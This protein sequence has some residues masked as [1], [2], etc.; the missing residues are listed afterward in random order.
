MFDS[1]SDKL[2]AALA[3]V[4]GRGTLTEDDV[5]AAMR[6]IRLALLEADV[7]FKVARAF[8]ERIRERA[9]QAEVLE[10]LT[11]G[12]T[13]VSIVNE[14]LTALLG[15]EQRKLRYQ[16]QPPT[17]VMLLGLQGS[18]K[19]TTA[20][21]LA[22]AVRKEGH[23]PLMV[24][25]DTY[26]PA[27]AQQLE[28]LGKDNQVPVAMPDGK[29][30]PPELCKRGVDEAKRLNCDVV[31]LDTAGRLQIDQTMLDELKEIRRRVTVHDT[32]LVVDA[33][34]GQEAV[35]VAKAFEEAVGVDGVILTKLDGDARGGAALSMR[36]SI[37]KPIMYS[38]I[39]EKVS[40]FE[41]FA[42]DRM[43]SRI[44]GMGDILTLI[45]RAQEHVDE[46]RAEEMVERSLAGKLTMQDW[47]DQMRQ[48]RNMGP[49]EGVL[50]MMPGGKKLLAQAQ[51]QGGAIPG[52]QDIKRM[53][54]IVL[55]M[56]TQERRHPEVIKGS[57]RKRIAAGSGTSISDVNKLLK[58]FEQMQSVMKMLGGGKGTK[59]VRGKARMLKQL[60]NIDTS[61]LPL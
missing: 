12:Q 32:V 15:G 43:A 40:E 23:R 49:L 24:A 51:Q 7:N 61:Q 6:E 52:E 45:E 39:G 47:L 38:G 41:A 55:S 53:E 48:L 22:L 57:R 37:G 13:I 4:R 44:L 50:G 18:G 42:P 17:V 1:L 46:K 27:A 3:D 21:K 9:V 16:S 8:V 19:T 59:G 14:E 5:S 20:A 31:I 34:T 35:N 58:G 28:R 56:T 36:E 60:R 10:S 29:A 2:Q 25:A 30:K 11:P 26:R 33:M 54:A